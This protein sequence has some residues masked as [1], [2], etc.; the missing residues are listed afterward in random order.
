MNKKFL[1][2]T[3]ILFQFFVTLNLSAAQNTPVFLAVDINS[4]QAIAYNPW[5][6]SEVKIYSIGGQARVSDI[7]G[8]DDIASVIL[9]APD[10]TFEAL[11]DDGLHNDGDENDGYY[12]TEARESTTPLSFGNYRLIVTDKAGGSSSRLVFINR[13]LEIPASPSPY[14]EEYI[15]NATPTFSW[16]NVE[17]AHL[18]RVT[19]WD[20]AGETIWTRGDITSTSV[21]YNNDGTGESLVDGNVYTW[22]V[23]AYSDDGESSNHFNIPFIYSSKKPVFLAVNINSFQA[24]RYN[25]W[26]QTG[27]KTYSIGGQAQVSD[28]DGLDDIASVI[29]QAP[30]GD[31]YKTLYDDGL[32]HDGDENDGYYGTEARESTTPPSLG[33]YRL[34]VTD[35]A[36][37]SSSRLVSINRYLDIP[38]NPSPGYEEYINNATP[39]FSWDKVDDADS[40]TVSVWD[41]AENIIWQQWGTSTSVVYNNDG[42][43]ES[44]VDGNV[45]TWE[46][47]AYLDDGESSNHSGIP[48]IYSSVDDQEGIDDDGDGYA[49]DLNDCDDSDPSIFPGADEICDGKDNDCD[50]LIDE[51]DACQFCT[52]SDGDG[53]YAESGCETD[54]DCDDTDPNINPGETEICSDG[55][56][57]N[58]DGKDASCVPEFNTTYKSSIYPLYSYYEYNDTEEQFVS[59]AS[60]VDTPAYPVLVRNIPDASGDI[61]LFYLDGWSD[62]YPYTFGYG[63]RKSA[64]YPAP[65]PAYEEIE[66]T[67]YIDENTNGTLDGAEPTDIFT[68]PLGTMKKLG[69]AENINIKAGKYPL[70]TWEGVDFAGE[71]FYRIRFF[72]VDASNHPIMTDLL[73]ES[74]IIDPSGPNTYKYNYTGNLFDTNDVIAIAIEA[75]ETSGR[76]II[77]RSRYFKNHL[78]EEISE[79][80]DGGGGGCFISN[81]VK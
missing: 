66:Y 8:L 47:F 26:Q 54:I 67:F 13:Y 65:G 29:L 35:K 50:G 71:L 42:T 39:T 17:D 4:Y 62:F 64:D 16:N 80:G 24:I 2:L 21:V 81:I 36:G 41:A 72:P 1:F 6:Q 73:F 46:I 55:I 76:R 15:N 28:I 23:F 57:Q 37:G 18:Y 75:T 34:I 40:Y 48:F 20:A 9:Q 58:C 52:D 51:G 78:T 43:G 44:L 74:D 5:Q 30:D 77:N 33:N 12:G 60:T 69:F 70:I 45:Y 79:D 11:Y 59:V 32:Q 10:G 19:V 22:G 7:D 25:P 63:S 3:I 56:D 31:V 68:L 14:Y 38:A 61:N 27:I 49:A 53:Y